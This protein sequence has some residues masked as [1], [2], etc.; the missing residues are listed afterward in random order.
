MI[1]FLF[2]TVR[3]ER[4]VKARTL[5]YG[6]VKE[7]ARL[8]TIKKVNIGNFRKAVYSYIK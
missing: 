4:P 7:I 6:N 5:Q 1:N 8:L 2:A 3:S